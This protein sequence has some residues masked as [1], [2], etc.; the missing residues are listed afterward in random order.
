M[1]S[2]YGDLELTARE[3]EDENW[4]FRKFLKFFDNI[5]EEEIDELVFQTADRVGTTIKCTSCGRCCKKLK[6]MLSQKDQKRLAD[7]LSMTV[8]QLRRQY[9]EYGDSEGES[10]WWI[11]DSP[12]PFLENNKCTVYEARPENCRKY[13]YLHEPEFISRTMGMIERTFTCP[14]VFYVMESLKQD[15]NFKTHGF[16]RY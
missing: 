6:F 2:D 16:Y 9:L 13:P 10:G 8:E 1:K 12:C 3:K 14:I 5:S 15:L 11:K 4:E 7:K